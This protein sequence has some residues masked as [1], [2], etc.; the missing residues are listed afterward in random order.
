MQ[1]YLHNYTY[2][3]YAWMMYDWYLDGWWT[4][5]MAS[6]DAI[7]CKDHELA[8]FLDKA[9]TI[10][11]PDVTNETTD[12]GIVSSCACDLIFHLLVHLWM[13]VLFVFY[14]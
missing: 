2:P 10:Q 4:S 1:A 13:H 12:I 7:D 14:Q 9:L 8:G 11:L 6:D 3:C 5:A